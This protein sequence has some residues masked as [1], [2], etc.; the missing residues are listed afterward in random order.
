MYRA[1][2]AIFLFFALSISVTAQVDEICRESGALPSLNSPFANIPYVFGRIVLKGMDPSAKFPIITITLSDPQQTGKRL[3]VERS[4]NYCFRRTSASGGSLVVEVDGI[5]VA[6]RSLPAFGP[7][8]QREDFEIHPAGSQRGVPPGVISAKFS[9]PQNARTVELYRKAAD[10]ETNKDPKKL[11]EILKEI[12]LID[13]PDFIA[14]AKLGSIY[15]EQNLLGEAEAAFRRSIESKLEYT[16]AWMNIGKIR[17]AKKQFDSAVEIFKHAASLDPSSARTF[18]LLGEAYLQAKKGSLGAEALN[19]A[20][21][22]DPVGMAE[23]HL[24]LARLYDLAGA[25]QLATREFKAFLTKVPE[26]SDKKRL[27][28]YIK[29]NPD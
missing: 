6:R 12:V 15:F 5:E 25:K 26:Y 14:W 22:L 19:K 28:K 21:E 17:V 18:Q 7:V 27:E 23:C 29:E 8:Q 20:I 11:V 16:P 9:H 10:A 24:L 4:G 3:I 2:F 1:A 13:P